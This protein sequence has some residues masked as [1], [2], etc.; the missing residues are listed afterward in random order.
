MAGS[1]DSTPMDPEMAA[2]AAAIDRFC[3]RPLAGR[4]ASDL[5]CE[6]THLRHQCD[7]LELEF[8]Q[9]A[10]AFAAT[11]EYDQQGSVSPI[12]WIRLNCHMGS[13]AAA[14][15]IAVGEHLERLSESVETMAE[16][17]IGFAHLALIAR[18]AAAIAESGT[19]KPFDETPLLKKAR[20]LSVGRFRNVCH[21]ARHAADPEGYAAEQA[22]GVEARV[23]SLS[24]GESGMVWVHGVLDAE[25]GAALRTAL[26]PLAKR[27]GQGDYRKRDRRFADALVEL[28]THSL[29]AGLVPQ[30]ASQRTHLQVTTT[31]ETLLQRAGAPAA[32]LEFSLPI[33]AA[34]VERLACDCNI[35]RI[36]LGTDSAVIDV[37]RSKRVVSPATRRALNLRDHCCRWPGCD[38]SASWSAA[39]HVVHWARGGATDLSNL[40][41]LCHRHHWMVH[42]GA[43]QLVRADGDQML[44]IPPQLDLY[45]QLA[46][47]PGVKAAA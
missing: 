8:S 20:D 28:A 45:Q 19:S 22:Q 4:S 42:E 3:E 37:G 26:E 31:L 27:K 32:D 14:D 9:T 5:T 35:T 23:L 47:G 21:H 36:L 24:G 33:S 30:R 34:S 11:D 41:L 1:V 10:A 15:R 6:L 12:H 40:V 7:R 43:W 2:L 46:R 16:G 17:E 13:G 44:A 18:T 29:D 25:G 39:H 38:R